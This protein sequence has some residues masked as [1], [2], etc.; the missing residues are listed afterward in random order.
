[1]ETNACTQQWERAWSLMKQG[2][3]DRLIHMGSK[4]AMNQWSSALT[5]TAP[6]MILWKLHSLTNL[7]KIT[8]QTCN[9]YFCS[10]TALMHKLVTNHIYDVEFVD[11]GMIINSTCILIGTGLSLLHHNT[12]WT[13]IST[14]VCEMR[15][16]I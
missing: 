7:W 6:N 11:I 16:G 14:Y 13:W 10:V 3:Y 8:K 4:V 12:F 9:L 1:M 2:L 15:K 5:T